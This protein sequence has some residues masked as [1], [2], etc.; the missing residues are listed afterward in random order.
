MK[1][2]PGQTEKEVQENS[3]LKTAGPEGEITAGMMDVHCN[4]F[5]PMFVLLYVI[6]YFLFMVAASYYHYLNFLG[7]DDFLEL[8]L[9]FGMIMMFACA[10]PLAFAFA[11]LA[12]PSCCHHNWSLAKHFPKSDHAAPSTGALTAELTTV[13][14]LQCPPCHQTRVY[15]PLGPVCS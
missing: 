13:L 11:T 1:E 7:Y 12:Y 3:G 6:H 9:Q 14:V 2:K 15:Y 10:F 4:S 8:A 5:F